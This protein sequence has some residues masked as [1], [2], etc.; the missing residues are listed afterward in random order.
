MR[1]TEGK[2][3]QRRNVKSQGP[4]GERPWRERGAEVG[5]AV[6]GGPGASQTT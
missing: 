1:E 6:R 3:M 5:I 4:E 2:R